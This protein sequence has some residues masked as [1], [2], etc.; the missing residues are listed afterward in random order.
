VASQGACS[1]P[2]NDDVWSVPLNYVQATLTE[3]GLDCYFGGGGSTKQCL[4]KCISGALGTAA[5][6]TDCY[7]DLVRCAIDH[8][9]FQCT[10]G[11]GSPSC[12]SCLSGQ[13]CV[14]AHATCSGDA[15]LL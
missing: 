14:V 11:V 7:S 9:A 13:G 4:D 12:V 1:G 3:C 10:S 2:D 5:A 6:C 15:P 8:C